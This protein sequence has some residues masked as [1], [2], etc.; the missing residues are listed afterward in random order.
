[1]LHVRHALKNNHLPPSAKQEGKITTFVVLASSCANNSKQIV[2]FKFKN[3]GPCGPSVKNYSNIQYGAN[4]REWPL[5]SQDCTNFYVELTFSLALS[6][7]A[8]SLAIMGR[9]G[10]CVFQRKCSMSDRKSVV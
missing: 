1:M 5:N 7:S 2:L 9:L 4:L 6:M 8:M 10:T 3:G